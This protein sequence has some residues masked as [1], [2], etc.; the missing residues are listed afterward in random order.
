MPAAALD[1]LH[2]CIQTLS[3]RVLSSNLILTRKHGSGYGPSNYWLNRLPLRAMTWPY[4]Q[5][6]V[7]YLKTSLADFEKAVDK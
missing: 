5:Q 3:Q 4:R 6:V 2:V 1:E 7:K